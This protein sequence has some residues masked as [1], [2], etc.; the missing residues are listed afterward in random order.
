[1]GL[2]LDV[3]HMGQKSATTALTLAQQYRYPVMDSHTGIR[4]DVN[5]S[6]PFGSPPNAATS[7][8]LPVNERSLLTSHVQIIKQLGGVI[9]L[10]EVPALLGTPPAPDPDPVQTWINNYSIALSLMGGKGVAIGTDADGLSPMLQ[11]DTIATNYPITVASKFGCP[12]GCPP[13]GLP[14]YQLGNRTYNFQNDGIA[15]YGLLPDFIQAASQSRP[16]PVPK[17]IDAACVQKCTDDYLTC[18]QNWQPGDHPAG[19]PSPCPANE[20][21]CRAACPFTGGG[22]KPGPAPTAQ[23]TALFH[24][25]EDTIEMWE[26]VENALMI[27]SL[28][29]SHGQAGQPFSE[30]LTARGGAPPYTWSIQS[31]SSLPPG[32]TL[33]RNG[34]ISGTGTS[35]GSYNFTVV[36]QDSSTPQ[37]L[38]SSLPFS[39]NMSPGN[40]CPSGQHCCSTVTAASGCLSG[41]IPNNM[42]CRPLC[43]AGKKCCGSAL[44]TGQC[45]SACISSSQSCP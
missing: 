31:G 25:A 10:G 23:I 36:V 37:P 34:T 43:P 2:L 14:P 6:T 4:C 27:T 38:T 26:K 22:T 9:G 8:G 21:T 28:T 13:N 40:A 5:C 33:N 42:A 17:V 29:Y 11:Q 39:M 32:L 20:V 1:M 35:S 19:T 15:T 45:D 44:S 30:T 16:I 7:A 18:V 24:S 3:A 12:A 41:C